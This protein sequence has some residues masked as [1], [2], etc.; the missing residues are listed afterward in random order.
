MAKEFEED[1]P[2]AIVGVQVED[3]DRGGA[4]EEMARVFVEEF[5][6]MGWDR[7]RIL[8]MFR[9][10]FYRGPHVVYRARGEPFVIRMIDNVL[11]GRR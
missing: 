3:D 8:D 6:R 7:D 9:N 1:D 4:L 2:F 5:A 11:G 10:P